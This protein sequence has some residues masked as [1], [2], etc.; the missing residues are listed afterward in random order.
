MQGH[1]GAHGSQVVVH[2]A[3]GEPVD[4]DPHED[5]AGAPTTAN[6]INPGVVEV[7]PAG[8]VGAESRG[9]DLLPSTTCL[10]VLDGLDRIGGDAVSER[11]EQKLHSRAQHAPTRRREL[12]VL[13]A[14][15]QDGDGEHEENEGD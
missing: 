10:P 14:E 13:F 6:L 11:L 12:V 15:D 2:L 8:L 3:V 7:V 5:T 1:G 4:G 9:L